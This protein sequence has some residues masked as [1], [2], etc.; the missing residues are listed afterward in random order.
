[1]K[2]H[3]KN[4]G[5][6]ANLAEGEIIRGLLNQNNI[7]TNEKE[8]QYIIIN[9]CTVKGET[10]ATREIKKT[11][12]LNPNAK[13]IITGCITKKVQL[14][15]PNALFVSTHNIDKIELAIKNNEN[16]TQHKE[17]T[18]LNFPRIK[19]KELVGIIPICSGCLDKCSYCSTKL[20]KG[21]LKSFS[22]QDILKQAKT[23]LNQ[24]CK[25]LWITAQ[26]TTCYGFDINS[27]LAVL[28]K[29]LT[30][31]EGEFCI[32]VGMGHPRYLKNFLNEFIQILKHPKIFKFL[33]L[34][35][36]SGN[37]Q[38]LEA[39][40]RQDTIE[41]FKEIVSKIKE[42]IPNFTLATDIIA[43]FPGETEIQ[44]NDSINLIKELKPDVLYI[45][46]YMKRESTPAFFLKNQVDEKIKKQ[47]TKTLS[48]LHQTIALENKQEFLN[49]EFEIILD[50]K[51]K[52]NT[53]FGRTIDYKPVT[54]L[55]NHNLGQK[56]RVKI[57]DVKPHFLIAEIIK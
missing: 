16:L 11:L 8:A 21:H 19:E 40:K 35:I 24:G 33:H 38:I 42:E 23:F 56:I 41:Q 43:G 20:I 55:G 36:Q 7:L 51:G 6:S 32:R 34:P 22:E 52:N 57:T 17:L 30:D 47:R 39:M 13:L 1:M 4:F 49:K 25:E 46:R 54:L 12:E 48:E 14:D 45:S 9:V 53:T 37:N 15:F 28:L 29:K 26:D 50:E 18:K 10:S 31:L 44:F 27:N 3:V 2:F 5:C